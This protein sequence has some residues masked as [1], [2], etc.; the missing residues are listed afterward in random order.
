MRK[1][2]QSLKATAAKDNGK[3]S[4]CPTTQ[5]NASG[6]GNKKT[7]KSILRTPNTA[8]AKKPP[9]KKWLEIAKSPSDNHFAALANNSNDTADDKKPCAQ[10]RLRSSSKSKKSDDSTSKAN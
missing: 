2:L 6:D 4:G 1:R 9:Q 7:P 3:N 5:K 8:A 10:N